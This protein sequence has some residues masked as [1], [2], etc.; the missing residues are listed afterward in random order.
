MLERNPRFRPWSPTAQPPGF[1]DRIEWALRP[2]ASERQTADIRFDRL[3]DRALRSLAVRE[4]DRVHPQLTPALH[5]LFLNTRV[6]PF[7]SVLARRA[8]ATAV[9]RGRL[10][11]I[12][13]GESAVP[14]CQ[15][16]PPLLPGFQPYCPFGRAGGASDPAPDVPAARRLVRRS[17]TRGAAVVVTAPSD[18]PGERRAARLLANTLERV[19]WHVRVSAEHPLVG[20]SFPGPYAAAVA[21]SR[22]PLIGWGQ[23]YADLPAASKL[24][25]PLASCGG[26]RR[27]TPRR[28]NLSGSCDPALDRTMRN[29]HMLDA[30]DPAGAA[31]L[32]ADADRSIVN[33]AAII[34]IASSQERFVTSARLGNF[35]VNPAIYMLVSEMWV[36]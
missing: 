4:P 30:T 11:E 20:G 21:R 23:W 28:F 1:P 15:A 31:R 7:D 35:Q 32:W 34:P 8:V 19:G 27:L 25:L 26:H 24:L 29:A 16:L 18:V 14:T 33:N 17:G 12:A 36:R 5:Y 10:S 6:Q 9:D 13:F 3:Q 22:E 2:S